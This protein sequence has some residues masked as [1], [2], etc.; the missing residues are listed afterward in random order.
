VDSAGNVLFSSENRSHLQNHNFEEEIQIDEYEVQNNRSQPD[1]EIEHAWIEPEQ[2]QQTADLESAILMMEN[3]PSAE[4]TP[5]LHQISK[6][7]LLLF[8]EKAV[9]ILLR[10]ASHRSK[11]FDFLEI[12]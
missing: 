3:S 11:C 1:N 12:F 6:E 8:S 7:H 9:K 4:M 2:K 10:A 5:L